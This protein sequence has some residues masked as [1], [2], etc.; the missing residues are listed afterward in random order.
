MLAYTV[1]DAMRSVLDFALSL[2]AFLH[3]SIWTEKHRC[4]CLSTEPCWPSAHEF[5]ELQSQLSQP[6]LKPIPPASPCYTSGPT[7][8]D[9]LI[10][11]NSWDNGTWHSDQPGSMQSSNFDDYIFK[12]GTI[13]ACYLNTSLGV[14]CEQGSVPILGVDARWPEDVETAVKFAAIH[15]LRVVIKNTG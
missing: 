1:S 2:Q 14:P 5:S 13:S 6:L 9:C 8:A 4:K 3:L 10:V 15:N 11:Q 7:S 12:N